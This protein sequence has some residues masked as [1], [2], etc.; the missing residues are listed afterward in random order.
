MND[1]DRECVEIL[2]ELVTAATEAAADS[3]QPKHARVFAA[4]ADFAR[5][6]RDDIK[7]G[8][9]TT[10]EASPMLEAESPR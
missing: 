8:N 5:I 3:H 6:I 7:L 4:L 10:V 9:A 2:T 1:N